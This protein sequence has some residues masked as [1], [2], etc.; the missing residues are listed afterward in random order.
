MKTKYTN[1]EIIIETLTKTDVLCDSENSYQ[2]SKR[3]DKG[4]TQRSLM[5]DIFDSNSDF[6][7][8]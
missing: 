7:T 8:E 6:W 4:M 1:P 3:L 2:A 5:S